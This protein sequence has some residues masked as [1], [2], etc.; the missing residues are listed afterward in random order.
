VISGTESRRVTPP[1]SLMPFLLASFLSAGRADTV[2][3]RRG[4]GVWVLVGL[5]LE[6]E[7]ER[8]RERA[9]GFSL[10]CGGTEGGKRVGSEL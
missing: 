6:R 1:P 8:E 7:R 2:P 5:R 9:N 10:N 3:H 4:K